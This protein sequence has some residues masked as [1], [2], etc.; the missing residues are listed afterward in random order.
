MD[1]AYR[2][3]AR[4]SRVIDGDSYILAVDVGYRAQ[5]EIRG[6][7]RGIDCP[8][9]GTPDGTLARV[10]AVT[11]LA[12][13]PHPGQ[14]PPLIVESYKDQRSFERWIVDVYVD[15]VSFA[16]MLRSEGHEAHAS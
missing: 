5:V 11:Q 1:P 3:R 2:H 9:R 7:L 4:C 15:G 8:E 10:F 14:N 12:P 6:R 13:Y 16:D